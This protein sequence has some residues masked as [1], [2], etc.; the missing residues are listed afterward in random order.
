MANACRLWNHDEGL[1]QNRIEYI[2]PD[3]QKSWSFYPT[4]KLKSYVVYV[5]YVEHGNYGKIPQYMEDKSVGIY[6]DNH[7]SKTFTSLFTIPLGDFPP[8]SY[9]ELK[10]SNRLFQGTWLEYGTVLPSNP[11]K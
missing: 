9:P 11:L 4:N 6:G 2:K 5:V 1:D 10:V 7:K 8:A 3:D